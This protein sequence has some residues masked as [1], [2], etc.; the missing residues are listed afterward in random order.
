MKSNFHFNKGHLAGLAALIASTSVYASPVCY[1]VG[2]DTATLGQRVVIDVIKEGKLA[3][4]KNDDAF[5]TKQTTYSANG[6]YLV[7]NPGNLTDAPLMSHITGHLIVSSG[8]V[9]AG[10]KAI[11]THAGLLV[12][13]VK[14]FGCDAKGV[15]NFQVPFNYECISSETTPTPTGLTCNQFINT[16]K[17]DSSGAINKV[18]VNIQLTQVANDGACRIFWK[19]D[20]PNPPAAQASGISAQ[21]YPED[22]L[23]AWLQEQKDQIPGFAEL[24]AQ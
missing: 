9:P 22:S 21:S 1:R 2:T 17:A 16:L 5:P 15:C 10:S 7:F 3:N 8:K 4:A 6:K 24:P 13:N 12:H 18:G 11:G 20:T 23:P 14:F 19:T